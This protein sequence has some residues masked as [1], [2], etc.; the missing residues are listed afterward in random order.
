MP[1]NCENCI[2]RCRANC[3]RG[4]V[5]FTRE[6][7]ESHTPVRPILLMRQ[8]DEKHIAVLADDNTLPK[9]TKNQINAVC[10][11]LG[12]DDR[13][14]VYDDRPP[15]CRRYGDESVMFMTCSYQ[16]KDGRVRSRQERR[17]VEKVQFEKQ[18]KT[19][20]KMRMGKSDISPKEKAELEKF[21]NETGL[22]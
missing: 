15:V 20:Q 18:E 5:P 1:L 14:S 2:K 13:C 11:F 6:F 9:K 12:L 3:C 8:L 19:V 16:D 21:G 4:P 17:H 22:I 7:V 10:P